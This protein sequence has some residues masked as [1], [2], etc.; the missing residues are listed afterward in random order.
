[1]AYK[2][3]DYVMFRIRLL[4]YTDS[5]I[6]PVVGYGRIRAVYVTGK[7]LEDYD[8]Y[9]VDGVVEGGTLH[10]NLYVKYREILHKITDKVHIVELKLRG[11]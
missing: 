10:D 7:Q 6:K 2:V 3:G 4:G 1:M 9:C 11:I 8:G 5:N